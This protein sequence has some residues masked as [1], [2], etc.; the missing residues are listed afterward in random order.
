MTSS[1]L[2]KNTVQ[3][4]YMCTHMMLRVC[5]VVD[6]ALLPVV[7]LDDKQSAKQEHRAGEVHVCS[8]GAEGLHGGRC[9]TAVQPFV[10]LKYSSLL[11]EST[12]LVGMSADTRLFGCGFAFVRWTREL[13]RR[14]CWLLPAVVGYGSMMRSAGHSSAAV[15][16]G[17]TSNTTVSQLAGLLACTSIDCHLTPDIACCPCMWLQVTR[18]DG[19]T[20]VLRAKNILIATGGYATKVSIAP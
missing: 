4:G 20:E 11:D 14:R 8:L 3:V 16:L 10:V 17:C 5:M 6:V 12:M 18:A 2:D 15:W 13:Q 7:V 9:C 19:S 1:L